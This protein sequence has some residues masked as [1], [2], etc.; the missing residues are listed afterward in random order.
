[1]R[2]HDILIFIKT[3]A[4][5]RRI[6]WFILECLRL[7]RLYLRPEKCEFE[8]TRIEYLR[9]IVSQGKVEMDPIKI[10]GVMDWPVLKNCKEVQAFLGFANFYRRFVE[11]FLHHAQ[12]L[13]ELTKKDSKWSWENMNNRLSMGSSNDSRPPQSSSLLCIILI[14]RSGDSERTSAS[15]NGLRPRCIVLSICGSWKIGVRSEVTWSENQ[16][17]SQ[18]YGCQRSEDTGSEVQDVGE[19]E[20]TL[21]KRRLRVSSLH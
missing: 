21:D 17:R 20:K 6:L 4:E 16:S 11:G 15:T 2:V 9:L 5:H 13:F 19:S 8:Q 1:M 12:P 7:H 3:L 14:R 18:R 10:V